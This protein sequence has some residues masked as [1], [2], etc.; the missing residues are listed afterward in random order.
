MSDDHEKPIKIAPANTPLTPPAA[1]IRAAAAASDS[2]SATWGL[3][4]AQWHERVQSAVARADTAEA[5]LEAAREALR[6]IALWAAA[7]RE[8]PMDWIYGRARAALG[9]A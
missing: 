9:E 5:D 6:E 7:G 3:T 2:I 4:E 1:L 8:P